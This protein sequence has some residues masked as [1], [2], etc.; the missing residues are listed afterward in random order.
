MSESQVEKEGD[1]RKR[2]EH[3]DNQGRREFCGGKVISIG[4][5]RTK[6]LVWG[7]P[8]QGSLSELV[9]TSTEGRLREQ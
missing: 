8:T 5:V 2:V 1:S 4:K 7:F 6:R 3:G 9:P